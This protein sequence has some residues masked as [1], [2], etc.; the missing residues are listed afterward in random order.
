M[1]EN[2]SSIVSNSVIL[3]NDVESKEPET[4]LMNIQHFNEVPWIK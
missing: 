4:L 2:F 1:N 3:G